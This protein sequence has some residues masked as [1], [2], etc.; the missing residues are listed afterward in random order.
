MDVALTAEKRLQ[1]EEFHPPLPLDEI[2]CS[3]VGS[4]GTGPVHFTLAEPDRIDV[5]T[6]DL[7]DQTPVHHVQQAVGEHPLLVIGDVL[8]GGEAKLLQVDRSKQLLLVDHGTQV[9]IEEPA[10][11]RVTDGHR[12]THLLPPVQ[13]LNLQVRH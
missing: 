2:G 11:L 3:R 6:T 9:S 5:V 8:R 13:K 7:Q 12:G 1:T 10:A 4:A